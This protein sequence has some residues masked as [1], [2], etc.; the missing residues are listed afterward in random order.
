MRAGRLRH[1]IRIEAR[2]DTVVSGNTVTTWATF[3]EHIPAAIET[4]TNILIR[5]LPGIKPSMRAVDEDDGTIYNLSGVVP[6]N[7]TGNQWM[8]LPCSSGVNGG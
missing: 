2:T 5:W 8:T 6:D 1:R 3:A 7:R 4:T